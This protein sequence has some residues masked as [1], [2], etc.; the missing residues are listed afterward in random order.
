MLFSDYKDME[1]WEATRRKFMKIFALTG[2]VSAVGLLGPFKKMGF[3][4]EGGMTPEEMREKAMQ[5]FKKPKQ[6]H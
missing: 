2:A 4:K 1:L 5:L 6:F 3:G